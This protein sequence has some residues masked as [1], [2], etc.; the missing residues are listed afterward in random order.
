M[1][2][3]ENGRSASPTSPFGSTLRKKGTNPHGGLD[4][5]RGHAVGGSVSSPV[6]GIMGSEIGGKLGRIVI[7]EVDPVTGELN[8]FDIE[9]LHTQAQSVGRGDPVRPRQTIGT[10]GGVGAGGVS[11]AHFQVFKGTDPTP[12][13]RWRTG[14]LFTAACSEPGSTERLAAS[15][16]RSPQYQ[17]PPPPSVY[18]LS[19][20]D[21]DSMATGSIAGSSRSSISDLPRLRCSR[22]SASIVL[23]P[24]V[25]LR[26]RLR[27]S[28]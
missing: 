13:R 23:L 8:G 27:R 20:R 12:A 6:Y 19:D 11:H 9:V 4:I 28:S 3:P 21:T 1:E 17:V 14:E 15:A 5:N 26:S 7:H 2:I 25:W 24:K 10:E 22:P 18:G 16:R